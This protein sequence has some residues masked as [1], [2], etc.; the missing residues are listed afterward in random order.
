VRCC[1]SS[2]HTTHMHK[3][4]R[5]LW[6]RCWQRHTLLFVWPPWTPQAVG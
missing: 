3:P 1:P 4:P 6:P 2:W 5:I